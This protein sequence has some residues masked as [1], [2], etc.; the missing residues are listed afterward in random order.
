MEDARELL[1]L[2]VFFAERGRGPGRASLGTRLWRSAAP[3]GRATLRRFPR[4]R[5]VADR[6]KGIL[7]A[8]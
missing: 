4:L 2:M 3:L 7:R 1:R 5:P 8:R 6:A